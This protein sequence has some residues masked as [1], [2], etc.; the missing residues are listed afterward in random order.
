MAIKE[1]C[2]AFNQA[3]VYFGSNQK[4]EKYDPKVHQV[5]LPQPHPF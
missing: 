3:L 1:A 5:N 2:D 4:R